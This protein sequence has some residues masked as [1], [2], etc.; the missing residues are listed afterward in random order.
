V[1]MQ[2]SNEAGQ[3]QVSRDRRRSCPIFKTSHL[4]VVSCSMIWCLVWRGPLNIYCIQSLLPVQLA[5]AMHWP[6]IH[7][8]AV[9]EQVE[10]DGL[11]LP[12]CSGVSGS[13][14]QEAIAR[15]SYSAV[16]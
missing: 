10:T 13:V 2:L 11:G 16:A 6:R 3:S 12:F 7:L 5:S 14:E 8:R 4:R 1:M 9:G 15:P